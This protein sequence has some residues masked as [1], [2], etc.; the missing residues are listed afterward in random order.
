MLDRTDRHFRWFAR[1]LSRRTLLY[2][3]MIHASAVRFGDRGQLLGFDPDEHPI[4]LQLGGDEPSE[5]AEAARIGVDWG[6]DQINLNVGCPSERVQHRRFGACLMAHPDV[7]ARA[8]EA[9][10]AAVDVPV[11]VKHRIGIDDLDRYEDMER[12]VRTVADAGCT[13]FTVH[14]RKAWLKGLSP[15]QNRTVPPLRHDEVHRLKATLP[16]LSIEINGGIRTVDEVRG[17]LAHVDAVM[18]G[19]AFVDDPWLLAQLEPVVFGEPSP[20]TDRVAAAE[21]VLPYLERLAAEGQPGH[22]VTRHLVDLFSGQ[23]GSRSWRRALADGSRTLG[24]GALLP[25]IDAVR[26]AEARGAA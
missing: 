6:Y 17:H 11:T 26:G 20:A 5:L 9:V 8:V 23:P 7:V 3:E 15:K 18:I 16:H 2:S 14:A 21:A 25:A 19:R 10:R 22:R 4:A 13:R 12:F 24:P 1:R